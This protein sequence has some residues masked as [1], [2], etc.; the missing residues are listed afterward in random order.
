M[1]LSELRESVANQKKDT[2]SSWEIAP[3]QVGEDYEDTQ[4]DDF[5]YHVTLKSAVPSIL[6][7]G[8]GP[9]HA[10]RYSNARS[11]KVYVSDR[12]GVQFWRRY[13]MRGSF[14]PG[15]SLVILRIP[16]KKVKTPLEVDDNGQADS[17]SSAWSATQVIR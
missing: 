9:G 1:K 15:D 11:S 17:G 12:D 4:P 8:L 6:K 3:D 14:K 2:G 13:V 5:Y 16:K 10:G 7:S